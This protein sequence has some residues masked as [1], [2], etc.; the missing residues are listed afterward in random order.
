[1]SLS[2]LLTPGADLRALA[3][4]LDVPV[5]AG[6][7]HQGDLSVIP[8]KMVGSY[9][10]PGT[11]VPA[12]GLPVLRGGGA[13]GNTHLLLA[14]GRVL[15]RSREPTPKKLAL[16]YLVVTDWAEAYLVHPEHGNTGIAP[17]RYVLRRKREYSEEL[18]L[19][20]D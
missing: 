7:Q 1:M 13:D 17:G 16:G 15:F 8:A 19:V 3:R 5:L 20:M 14:S 10:P 6:L 2:R 4:E 11:A 18:R 12:A 9:C